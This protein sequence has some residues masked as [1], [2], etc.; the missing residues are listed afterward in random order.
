MSGVSHYL[1]LQDTEFVSK[2]FL[3]FI[4]FYL[5][6]FYGLTYT[7][8][9]SFGSSWIPISDDYQQNRNEYF[10]ATSHQP[11]KNIQVERKTFLLDKKEQKLSITKNAVVIKIKQ[12]VGDFMDKTAMTL[13]KLGRKWFG[14]RVEVK[15]DSEIKTISAFGLEFDLIYALDQ[16]IL[17]LTEFVAYVST[18]VLFRIFWPTV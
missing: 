9:E 4:I 8:H 10:A 15:Y 12:I 6:C 3:C 14:P 11:Q 7:K 5:T 18:D 2:L 13:V 1:T 16:F 17:I